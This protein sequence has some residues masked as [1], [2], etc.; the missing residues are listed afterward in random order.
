MQS[1]IISN[2]EIFCSN[3]AAK[4]FLSTKYKVVSSSTTQFLMCSFSYC[5][6]IKLCCVNIKINNLWFVILTSYFYLSN[7]FPVVN[8][9]HST[10]VIIVISVLRVNNV[11]NDCTEKVDGLWL[12]K[13]YFE[14]YGI[15]VVKIPHQIDVNISYSNLEIFQRLYFH[16][17]SKQY[18]SEI[19]R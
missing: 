7:S 1:N 4:C 18:F 12:I 10:W 11:T 14:S 19:F 2:R 15:S 17:V 16:I 13:I 8:V 5:N 9:I 3:L 6:Y